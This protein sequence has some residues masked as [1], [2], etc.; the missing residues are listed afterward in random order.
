MTRSF[1]IDYKRMLFKNQVIYTFERGIFGLKVRKDYQFIFN[2]NCS[3]YENSD[4]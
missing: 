4:D 3:E 1:F 2:D